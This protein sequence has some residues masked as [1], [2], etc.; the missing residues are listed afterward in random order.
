MS[1]KDGIIPKFHL[2]PLS[3]IKN[4]IPGVIKNIRYKSP[5]PREAGFGSSLMNELD[6]IRI[7]SFPACL[8]PGI[9]AASSGV[10]FDSRN[11]TRFNNFA[12]GN[13]PSLAYS[14][15]AQGAPRIA[16]IFFYLLIPGLKYK[17]A[18]GFEEDTRFLSG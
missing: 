11:E 5:S 7:K 6:Y 17:P 18:H 3:F 2:G 1:E 16:T 9:Q 14:L 4:I 15:T 12:K 8:L 13:F 10:S